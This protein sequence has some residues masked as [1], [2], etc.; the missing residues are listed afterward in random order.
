MSASSFPPITNPK[1]HPNTKPIKA[2]LELTVIGYVG[3]V[4]LNATQNSQVLTVTLAHRRRPEEDTQWIAAKIWGSRAA[5][6]A[7]HIKPGGR[8][9]VRG[10]PQVAV[11]QR[12]D[13][14]QGQELVCH[15]DTLEFVGSPRP[16]PM[17]PP[18]PSLPLP[19][20][21]PPVARKRAA[22]PL[23]TTALQK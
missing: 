23:R 12:R 7:T 19:L 20:P 15:V 1:P 5:S 17:A 14:T 16:E 18:Q 9:L 13:G 4:R 22:K 10:R 21:Q 6:L 8:M 3:F 2:M 11:F